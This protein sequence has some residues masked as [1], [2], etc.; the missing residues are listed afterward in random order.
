MKN[1]DLRLP[2]SVQDHP[3]SDTIFYLNDA[4][5]EEVATFYLDDNGLKATH[6]M[7]AV[8]SHDKLVKALEECKHWHQGDKWRG[9]DDAEQNGAWNRHM[10]IIDEALAAAKGE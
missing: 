10:A 4:H 6:A 7:R 1:K 5:G 9:S 3:T 2:Y 8:N